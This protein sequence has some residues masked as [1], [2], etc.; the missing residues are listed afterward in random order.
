MGKFEKVDLGNIDDKKPGRGWP[1]GAAV[2][3]ACSTSAARGSLVW[4]PGCGHGTLGT[5]CCGRRPTYKVEE[6]GHDVNSGPVFLR[7]KR[8]IGSS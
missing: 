6:D 7:K 2:K 5:R 4:I 1:S 3:C 8:K